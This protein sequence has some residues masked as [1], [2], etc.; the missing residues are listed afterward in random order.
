MENPKPTNRGKGYLINPGANDG[1]AD[2][3]GKGDIWFLK[4]R[5]HQFD[6][7]IVATRFTF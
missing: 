6:D 3:F 1:I 4:N 2:S 7:G 5:P